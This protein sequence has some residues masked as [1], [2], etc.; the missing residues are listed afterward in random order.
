MSGEAA[1]R[2]TVSRVRVRYAETDKMGVAYHGE[3]LP[4]FEVGR[5][6]W[7]RGEAG[8]SY[9]LLEG[10][11]WFLP[12]VE[13]SCRYHLP[14]RYDDELLVHTSAPEISRARFVFD[15]EVRRADTDELL[16]KGRTV[17]A[18]T[19]AQGRPR[20]LPRDVFDWLLGRSDELPA[21]SDQGD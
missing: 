10:A 13:L 20:R 9:A 5:T 6:D 17:H 19:D 21:R 7:I 3:Y 11:G 18:I 12:V 4:W 14:A 15:Y 16:T 8:R 2:V 1:G